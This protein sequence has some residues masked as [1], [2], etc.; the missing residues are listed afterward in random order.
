MKVLYIHQYFRKPQDGGAIRS[1]YLAKSLVNAGVEVEMVTSHNHNKVR[2]ENVDGIN[3]HFLPVSYDNKL[4]FWRRIRS[5]YSFMVKS[6]NYAKKIENVDVVYATSTPLTVGLIALFLKIRNKTPFYFEVRDLWPEAPIQMGAIKNPISKFFLRYLEK[7]IYKNASKIIALSPGMKEGVLDV[8]E[9]GNKVAI[10]PN[11]SD[12]EFFNIEPKNNKDSFYFGVSENFVISY[13]G[14][15][16][17]VNNL[18]SLLEVALACKKENLKDVK[19]LV[20]GRGGKLKE[21]KDKANKMKLNNIRF[22][23][24][25]NRR[26]VKKLLN[27]TDASFISFDSKPILETNSPNKFF[28][29]IASG[30]ICIVNNKGWIKDLIEENNIGFY[31]SKKQPIAFVEK[32]KQYTKDIVLTNQTKLASRKLAEE[33]F[34][35]DIIT[36]QFVELFDVELLSKKEIKGHKKTIRA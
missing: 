19:F 20:A 26:E 28:D 16:G 31:Y 9:E 11:M 35:R 8:I 15:I 17:E 2:Q 6:Y 3:I 27:V 13:I 30:K 21:I 10:L 23:G 4:N 29:S 34:S 7:I 14:A 24:F 5:F 18:E 12:C 25:L 1:Y 32:I 33:H 36:K 22:V